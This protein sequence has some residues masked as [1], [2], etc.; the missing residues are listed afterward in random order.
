MLIKNKIFLII[1]CF[2]SLCALSVKLS[3]DE[4]N[5]SASEVLIDQ[6]NNIVIGK[7]LVE[8]TDVEGNLIKSNKATYEK[9]KEFLVAEGSVVVFD[10]VGNI[11]KSEKATYDNIKD[12]IVT[13]RNS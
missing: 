8:V 5:I 11:L 4:F 6:K 12:L 10:T 2:L 3:A 9:S 13:Y 1:V 7:G